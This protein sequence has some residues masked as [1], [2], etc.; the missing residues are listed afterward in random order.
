LFYRHGI[1]AHSNGSLL[2][3]DGGD[4]LSLLESDE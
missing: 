4:S 2:D 1:T 3:S